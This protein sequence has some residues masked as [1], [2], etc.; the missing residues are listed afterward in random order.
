M[1][2]SPPG[3]GFRSAPRYLSLRWQ[4]VIALAFSLALTQT[5]VGTFTHRQSANYFTEEQRV[6]QI[7]QAQ[8]LQQLLIH[9]D[10]ELAGFK[11]LLPALGARSST[12]NQSYEDLLRLSLENEG[13]TLAL[14]WDISD[15][16]LASC[17]GRPTIAWPRGHTLP[18]VIQERICNSDQLQ[19]RHFQTLACQES[20]LQ[21]IATPVLWQGDDSKTLIL[22]RSVA[23]ALLT[24]QNISESDVA[25]VTEQDLKSTG[26]EFSAVTQRLL[27]VPTLRAVAAPLFK[28]SIE[29]SPGQLTVS[30]PVEAE[31]GDRLVHV[32]RVDGMAPGVSALIIDDATAI[33]DAIR[34]ITVASLVAGLAGFVL[35]GLLLGWLLHYPLNR[36]TRVATALPLLADGDYEALRDELPRAS[37]NNLVEDELDYLASMA[38]LLADRMETVERNRHEAMVRVAWLANHDPLTHTRNRTRLMEELATTLAHA[39]RY[40]RD[41]AL[42]FLDLDRFKEVNDL[43]SHQVGDRLLVAIANRLEKVLRPSDVLARV[44]GDEF[45]VLLPEASREEALSCANRI[46]KA[47]VGERIIN[48]SVTHQCTASIGIVLFPDGDTG[49][50]D[51]LMRADLAMYQAKQV[52]PGCHH[53]F[54]PADLGIGGLSE[55]AVWRK[56]IEQALEQDLLVFHYQPVVDIRTGKLSHYEALLRMQAEDELYYPD[57][58]IPIAEQT[59]QISDIDAW[60]LRQAIQL[61]ANDAVPRLAV[62]LSSRALRPGSVLD[63]L[64]TLLEHHRLGAGRLILE[65]TETTAMLSLSDASSTMGLLQTH[66]VE[67]ALDD[68]GSG[69]ASYAYLRELPVSHVKIDGA[70]VRNLPGNTD[71]RLFVKSITDMAHTLGKQVVAEFVENDAV[72]SMLAELGVDFAQGYHLGR[73]EP[74]PNAGPWPPATLP[75]NPG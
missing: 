64:P 30:P 35:A 15:V 28:Q 61:L 37:G 42:L 55:R 22:A 21:Y 16:F 63:D 46:H 53:I 40:D 49:P 56:R 10:H 50:D 20:C 25:L 24:F 70:F 14:E 34:R 62:N 36:L 74:T 48:G 29:N 68:F 19:G 7:R 67:I 45:V 51:L 41:G 58:F 66:G 8:E 23:D 43:S 17:D 1:A 6:Q 39:Q 38:S 75:D 73:P 65:V 32:F 11:N 57:R 12:G 9:N 52:G 44:G 59:G 2:V 69:Y 3:S 4:T 72:Y 18:P 54:G 71:D 60:V 27:S 31:V 13:S 47:V 33:R 5:I 26:L